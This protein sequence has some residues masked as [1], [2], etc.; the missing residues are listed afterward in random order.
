MLTVK[1]SVGQMTRHTTAYTN[2]RSSSWL[3]CANNTGSY[4]EVVN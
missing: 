1:G 4:Y 3:K 2:I